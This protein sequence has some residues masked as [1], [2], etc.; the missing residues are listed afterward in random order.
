[1]KTCAIIAEY[2]PLHKG[3]IYH[4]TKAKEE[5]NCDCL[6]VILSTFFSQ[7]GL[8]SL[9]SRKDK[10]RLAIE[11]G[12]DLV[13]E[14]PCIYASQSADQFAKYSIQSLSSLHIDSLCFG[15]ET[16]NLAYLESLLEKLEPNEIDPSKSWNQNLDC[17]LQANDILGLQYIRWCKQYNIQPLLIQRNN[18]YKSATQTR[19]DFFSN[20][21]QFNDQYFI[22]EQKWESYYPYLRLFLQMTKP[23]Q[24]RS[25]FLVNEGI[26]YRLIE[27]AKKH[28]SWNNFLEASISKTYTRARIQRTCLFIM[29]QIQK[30]EMQKHDS[31]YDV[32]VL[33]F[34]SIGRKLLKEHKGANIQT[35]FKDLN[36]F[37][38]EIE[39]KIKALWQSVTTKE[40]EDGIY[41]VD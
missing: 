12:A 20:Q 28:D 8:P 11:Y 4:I 22:P 15:S 31:F 6:V 18:T 36:P 32:R 25:Y 21:S 37:A 26:E 33:G 2:N 14:L 27:N 9:L 3:H 29:L 19:N 10:A 41:V 24:L 5:S 38:Q 17:S 34:N 39:L 16:N 7:R 30:E 23:E 1:M 35:Q 13:L 40:I